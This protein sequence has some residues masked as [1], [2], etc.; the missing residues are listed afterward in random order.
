VEKTRRTLAAL[1]T[2]I[3]AYYCALAVFTLVS[4]PDVT[5]QWIERSGDQDF[6]Y[7][8]GTFLALSAFGATSIAVLGTSTVVKGVATVRGLPASWL[9]PLLVALPL[10]WFWFSYRSIGAGVLDRHGRMA[11]QRNAAIQFGAVCLGYLV[12]WLIQRRPHRHGA[13]AF[14]GA[15]SFSVTAAVARSIAFGRLHRPTRRRVVTGG[16]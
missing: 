5:R 7:D 10:H 9:G 6:K 3:G 15:L 14:I 16:A 11:V 12:L 1:F 8:Y 4:L 13:S 2:L